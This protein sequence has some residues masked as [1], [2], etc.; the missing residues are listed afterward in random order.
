MEV[1]TV[2]NLHIGGH[3]SAPGWKILDIEARDEVNYVGEAHNLSRFDD[4]EWDSV[5][6]SH[7]LEHLDYSFTQEA[8]REWYRVL[9]PGGV[10]F[11]SVPDMDTL[12]RLY[13][14]KS[15]PLQRKMTIIHHMFGGHSG[16]YDYHFMCFDYEMLK[17]LLFQ[18]G[19]S[20]TKKVRSFGIFD[21]C[22]KKTVEGKMLSLNVVAMK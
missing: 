20:Q 22:S 12:C 4:G 13:L 21:D 10:L 5:Y 16:P 9:R 1:K 3:V 11:V 15:I 7:V 14:D 8:I 19:F 17:A 6:V 2:N 18:A